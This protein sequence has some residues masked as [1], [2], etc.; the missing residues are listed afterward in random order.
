[1]TDPY[2]AACSCGKNA[3]AVAPAFTAKQRNRD[4]RSQ[5]RFVTVNLET[6]RH[7]RGLADG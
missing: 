2:R 3:V 4:C 1:M 7:R 5:P 6:P